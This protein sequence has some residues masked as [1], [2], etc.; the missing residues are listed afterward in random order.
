MVTHCPTRTF[1]L[2]ACAKIKLAQ[3]SNHGGWIQ[4]FNEITVHFMRMI[5][6]ARSID[7]PTVCRQVGFGE[8]WHRRCKAI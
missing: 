6:I 5:R 3:D 2:I 7:L 1:H 8:Y 4:G